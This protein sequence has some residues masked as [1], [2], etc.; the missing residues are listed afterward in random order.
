MSRS[1]ATKKA[2]KKY[3][4]SKPEALNRAKNKYY[5][6][7]K[8]KCLHLHIEKDKDIISQLQDKNFNQYV[9]GLI[10]AD[11]KVNKE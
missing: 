7:L 10:R 6:L 3:F 9:K 2:Q 1:E 8:D 5:K 4:E 11:M